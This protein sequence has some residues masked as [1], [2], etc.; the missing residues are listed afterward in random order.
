MTRI[1]EISNILLYL[2]LIYRSYSLQETPNQNGACNEENVWNHL[3]WENKIWMENSIIGNMLQRIET[4][5]HKE[6]YFFFFFVF[7]DGFHLLWMRF[8]FFDSF[9]VSIQIQWQQFHNYYTEER[10]GGRVLCVKICCFRQNILKFNN[11]FRVR[12]LLR[13]IFRTPSTLSM[14]CVCC[15]GIYESGVTV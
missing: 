4:F 13:P 10:R 9:S 3:E 14:Y 1:N 8:S 15:M 2:N 12:M 7:C 11:I 6:N 5:S